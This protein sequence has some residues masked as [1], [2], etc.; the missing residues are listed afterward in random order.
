MAGWVHP[1]P[2]PLSAEKRF[3]ARLSLRRYDF[4]VMLLKYPVQ[5]QLG[6]SSTVFGPDF[7]VLVLFRHFLFPA[8][9]VLLYSKVLVLP[10]ATFWANSS[11]V[12]GAIP[13]PP[14]HEVPSFS[15]R[16]GFSIPTQLLVDLHLEFSTTSAR[17]KVPPFF[18][19]TAMSIHNPH[20]PYKS[21]RWPHGHRRRRLLIIN[22][23]NHLQQRYTR[24]P[25][26]LVYDTRSLYSYR[27]YVLL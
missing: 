5:S 18:F 10:S 1:K 7:G 19:Q 11:V 24:V 16:R 15:S 13:S 14:R 27:V 22:E 23:Q 2:G 20:I 6:S 17:Q 25:G 3:L 21:V 9:F 26:I 8:Q 4:V 12:T